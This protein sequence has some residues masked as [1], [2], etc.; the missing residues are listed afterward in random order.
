MEDNHL[1]VF[2]LNRLLVS[3]PINGYTPLCVCIEIADAHGIE[4]LS[5]L[6]SSISLAKILRNYIK[7]TDFQKISKNISGNDWQYIARFV[8]KTCSWPQRKLT[9]AYN[10][11]NEFTYNHDPLD[12]IPLDFS[13]GQQSPTQIHS[14]NACMLYR[15]CIYHRLNLNVYTTIEQMAF[16]IRMLRE[17][18]LSISRRA[19]SFIKTITNNGNRRTDLINILLLSNTET[20]DPDPEPLVQCDLNIIPKCNVPYPLFQA[21]YKQLNDVNVL[22]TKV[23]PSSN[24]GAIA[25]AALCYHID[26]SK[27]SH[28]Q[29]EYQSLRISG[30]DNYIPIDEWMKYWFKKNPA[31][32]DLSMTFNPTFPVGYYSTDT[33]RNIAANEGY[34]A[35]ELAS[36]SPYEL[37]QLSKVSE[38]F[39]IGE[40]PTLKQKFTAIEL[41]DISEV[42]Y[43]ELICYG[44]PDSQ[45][46]PLSVTELI[47]MFDEQQ[48]F[49][50]P[51]QNNAIFSNISINKLKII[52]KS[53]I[54]PHMNRY[55][56][57]ETKTLREQLYQN[58]TTIEGILASTDEASRIFMFSYKRVDN[59]QKNKIKQTLIALLN[60]GM[61]MRGWMGK[62]SETLTNPY[63]IK[64]A[65]VI[66]GKELQVDINVTQGLS[67]YDS[68]CTEL[69]AIGEQI[70]NLP[71]VIQKD[72]IYTKSTR[73]KD[74]FTI[75][76]RLKIVKMGR[77]TGNT[78]SCI[79]LS[80][81]W[82][83]A[84][85]H[86]YLTMLS[87]TA[88]FDLKSL[89]DIA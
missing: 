46:L 77:Q 32:F 73:E 25:L 85:A 3:G 55:I 47:E 67:E 41:Q 34:S 44:H 14:I 20:E 18:S 66:S 48:C 88:P 57:P 11:L 63:P 8:N 50:N 37:L 69:N 52:I 27:T 23:T 7:F 84:S 70:N 28:P 68:L 29:K 83:C 13:I 51:F 33:L 40:V 82:I 38:T 74:G 4:Y 53:E 76:E 9:E 54:I 78:S 35:L 59:N 65:P 62:G 19:N 30:K 24:G 12:K 15:T 36:T 43:G 26:I 1:E 60:A 2:S 58:I 86:K 61:Y 71:L 64:N 45:Y 81:N 75:G 21:I 87:F 16:A 22:H 5:E 39:H 10:F 80:S 79:R 56:S 42:P 17:D 89:R 49:T 6:D 72:G 31:L